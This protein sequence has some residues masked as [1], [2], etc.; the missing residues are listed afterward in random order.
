[1][2]TSSLALWV[3]VLT[4]WTLPS[5]A[6]AVDVD[7]DMDHSVTQT[8]GPDGGEVKTQDAQ[9][10]EFTLKIPAHALEVDTPIRI[11]P[12]LRQRGMPLSKGVIAGAHLE[13]D[14]LR[15]LEPATLTV[16]L[17]NPLPLKTEI[18]FAYSQK[19]NEFRA[20]QMTGNQ[21]TVV[22]TLMHFSGYGIGEGSGED[23]S[24]MRSQVSR[25]AA[26]QLFHQLAVV[27][28]TNFDGGYLPLEFDAAVDAVMYDFVHGPY[29]N[30]LASLGTGPTC[31]LEK[32]RITQ[33]MWLKRQAELMA[34]PWPELPWEKIRV[35]TSRCTKVLEKL[36]DDNHDPALMYNLMLHGK[37]AGILGMAP[38]AV[39]AQEAA[40]R[41]GTFMVV[42]DARIDIKSSITTWTHL[43]TRFLT[44][45]LD[46]L[47]LGPDGQDR[48]QA[49]VEATG[50]YDAPGGCTATYHLAPD[51]L[52]LNALKVD[53]K[54][55]FGE[56]DWDAP[57]EQAVGDITDFQ[58]RYGVG[59]SNE[60]LQYHCRDMP[61]MNLNQL[62]IG[63]FM[64][65]HG[66]EMQRPKNYLLS[67]N[68][69]MQPIG[70]VMVAEK[71]YKRTNVSAAEDSKIQ[72]FHNP[73]AK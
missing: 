67:R 29:A 61:P 19:S 62:W 28:K 22:L 10:Q 18:P 12:I 9:G 38:E 33:I 37:Q 13:P 57:F 25:D 51:P 55:R 34:Y 43:V 2:K 36:C 72:I 24:T 23:W 14:G 15:L 54:L 56:G 35:I 26:E 3:T 63:G 20:Q 40:R 45:W 52:T 73:G 41:C 17:K 58:L 69:T 46:E 60:N 32:K 27:L 42:F 16:V 5:F 1:M 66:D 47:M 49:F 59:L 21:Q 71:V 70:T 11:T 30:L 48:P 53:Y 31:T 8:I 7:L 68:F 39:E 65:L 50:Q 4:F 64:P 6:G 44:T